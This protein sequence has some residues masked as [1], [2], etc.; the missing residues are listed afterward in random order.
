MARSIVRFPKRKPD[1]ALPM[2]FAAAPLAPLLLLSLAAASD[3]V[4]PGQTR[5]AS[6]QSQ[7]V[8]GSP[9]SSLDLASPDPGSR[10]SAS[11][12]LAS[13]HLIEPEASSIDPVADSLPF[14]EIGE[15]VRDDRAGQVRIEQ[16][17]IIR[18][19]PRSRGPMPSDLFFAPRFRSGEPRTIERKIGKCLPAAS[20]AAVRPSG[21]EK[22]LL[23]MRDQ[24]I[25]SATLERACSARDFYSGFYVAPSADGKVCVDR[26]TL[27][28][29][30]GANC[31]LT[32]IRQL[33]DVDD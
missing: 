18:I 27:Q 26:D 9:P 24:R 25:V 12:H 33:V 8:A 16:R 11:R 17:V 30:S 1:Q 31:K 28:S 4:R 5:L 7:P 20:I 19:S 13:R 21:R 23:F 32:R 10:D 15:H 29:R 2:T 6:V 3:D 22:L 14:D